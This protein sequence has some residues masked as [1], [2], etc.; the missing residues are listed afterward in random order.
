MIDVISFVR[1][2]WGPDGLFT[3]LRAAQFSD[4]AAENFLSAME[5]VTPSALSEEER[6]RA[7]AILF[8]L[9]YF[10]AMYKPRC[11]LSGADPTDYDGFMADCHSIVRAKI[12]ELL[13]V[14]DDDFREGQATRPGSAA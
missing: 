3:N 6:R 14:T 7:A 4:S 10:A 1:K 8:E 11:L 9:P 12:H 5:A 2:E 13:A